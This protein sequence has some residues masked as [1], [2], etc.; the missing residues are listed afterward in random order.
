MFSLFQICSFGVVVPKERTYVVIP[1]NGNNIK[2][3][4]KKLDRRG[5]FLAPW[6]Y[7]DENKGEWNHVDDF[8]ALLDANTSCKLF[9]G[10]AQWR[11][12]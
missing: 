4:M 10:M 2:E 5:A 6:N 9:I 1:K 12:F 8:D 11:T 3:E 7:C